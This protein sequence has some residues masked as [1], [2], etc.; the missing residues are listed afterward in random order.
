MSKKLLAI[1]T[2]IVCVLMAF[3]ACS[4]GKEPL[5]EDTGK[6]VSVGGFVAETDD[7]VY[8]INGNELYTEDNTLNKV[9]KG[10]PVRGRLLRGHSRCERQNLFRYPECGKRQ[11]RQYQKY[12]NR[13]LLR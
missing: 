7:Y 4:A 5:T 6:N 3:T 11:N 12:R 1:V 2:V 10:A 13:I 9:E 8:F